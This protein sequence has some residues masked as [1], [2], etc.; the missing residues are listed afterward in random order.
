M[1]S[2]FTGVN[3]EFARSV[4]VFVR[5]TERDANEEMG[6]KRWKR[7]KW[8]SICSIFR[9]FFVRALTVIESQVYMISKKFAPRLSRRSVRVL[10]RDRKRVLE[11]FRDLF[12]D[13]SIFHRHRKPI[14]VIQNN[15]RL[16][17]NDDASRQTNAKA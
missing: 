4:W 8:I 13:R 2:F 7:C 17:R 15:Q 16:S 14:I 12:A 6:E 10:Q 9:C 5:D 11:S 3:D 1:V